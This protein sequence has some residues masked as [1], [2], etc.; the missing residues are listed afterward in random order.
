[1]DLKDEIVAIVA[2]SKIP[3]SSGEL[4]QSLHIGKSTIKRHLEPLLHE[5]T[6]LRVG[7]G[8]GTR[9]IAGVHS[10]SVNLRDHEDTGLSPLLEARALLNY[11]QAPLAVRDITGYKRSFVDN[12]IP[13]RS[14]LLPATLA[15]N[16]RLEG[17]MAGQQPAGTYA[18]KVLEQL[19]IDLSWSSSKL[20]GNKYSLLATEELFR[21]GTEA[22]DFDTVML[23][24]HKQAIE[25]LV[26]AVPEYGLTGP[27]IGNLHSILMQDL[28]P[29]PEVLGTIRSKIVNISGTTYTP[30]QTPFLLQEMF[31]CIVTKAREIKNPVESAFFLWVN[32]AYLQPFEDGNK[33]TSRLAA[34]IPL[35]IYNSAPLSFLDADASDYSYAMMGIYEKCNVALAVDLFEHLYR[36]SISRY[37]VTLDAMGVPDPF[38]LLQRENLNIAIRYIV[39]ERQD[40]EEIIASIGI[41][42]ADKAQFRMLLLNELRVLQVHNC[43]RYRL[44]LRQVDNWIKD[45]RPVRG[46]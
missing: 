16:L 44:T 24:N 4:A 28:L 37:K 40:I 26:D 42:S 27:V 46:Q 30:L 38:R 33:R 6:L 20:E 5:G 10:S 18:R 2:S 14:A 9:Y 22:G 45:G 23:L 3:L 41:D 34:N 21:S 43:A 13:N 29:D 17:Q 7:N 39:V 19:L 11:L 25:F 31:E 1:M 32:L 36:R 35:M 15:E 12:Y 8:R